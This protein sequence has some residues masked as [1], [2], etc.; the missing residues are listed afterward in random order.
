MSFLLESFLIL[1]PDHSRDEE[2]SENKRNIREWV[3][4]RRKSNFSFFGYFDNENY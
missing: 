3:K 2:I 1:P 4:I